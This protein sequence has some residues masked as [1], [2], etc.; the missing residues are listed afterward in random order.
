MSN[1]HVG[2]LPRVVQQSGMVVLGHHVPAGVAEGGLGVI[3][4]FD[5]GVE[6]V[7][8]IDGC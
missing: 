5:P 8:G 1:G 7:S 3:G 6:V 4:N 2:R